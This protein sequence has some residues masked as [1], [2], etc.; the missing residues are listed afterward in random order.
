MEVWEDQDLMVALISNVEENELTGCLE[1]QG[2]SSY[3]Y[4]KLSHKGKSYATHRLSY[5]IF[6]RR[7]IADGMMILH[8]CDN[9]ACCNPE[10][11]REGT[12]RDN[13][14]DTRSRDRYSKIKP[15]RFGRDP[16]APWR[17]FVVGT[18]NGTFTLLTEHDKEFHELEGAAPEGD[19]TLP[20][21]TTVKVDPLIFDAKRL[22]SACRE[23][24]YDRQR[25][26]DM[27][28]QRK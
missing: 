25:K 24:L 23:Y 11:L 3:G 1:W 17:A 16:T 27:Y 26:K 20:C 5:E 2:P 9:E 6:N 14:N 22:Y 4:G 13:S 19:Y 8:G 15:K 12:V 10:H 21:G 28:K 18:A 7:K